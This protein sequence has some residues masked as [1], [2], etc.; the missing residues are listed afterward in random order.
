MGKETGFPKP[1]S[2]IL[3]NRAAKTAYRKQHTVKERIRRRRVTVP[4]FYKPIAELV[5]SPILKEVSTFLYPG[6]ENSLP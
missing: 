4:R 6:S 3:G 2:A 1:S 5:D